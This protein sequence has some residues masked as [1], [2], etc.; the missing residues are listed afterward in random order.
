MW[1]NSP[2]FAFQ[3]CVK[4]GRGHI[5][6]YMIGIILY[7]EWSWCDIAY[8]GTVLKWL[9]SREHLG[10]YLKELYTMILIFLITAPECPEWKS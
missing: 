5:R 8:Y 6:T 7:S 10:R 9:M 2:D 1:S 4:T 3:P